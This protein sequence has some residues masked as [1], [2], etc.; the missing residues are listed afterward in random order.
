M[1]V[2]TRRFTHHHVYVHVSFLLVF[3]PVRKVFS[4]V[5]LLCWA[6]SDRLRKIRVDIDSCLVWVKL[7]NLTCK[8]AVAEKEEKNYSTIADYCFGEGTYSLS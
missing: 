6:L 2:L 4:G 5:L 7:R 1:N 3:V 8:F